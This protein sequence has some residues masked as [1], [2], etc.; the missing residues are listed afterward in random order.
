MSMNASNLN[1][2][3]KIDKHPSTGKK[4][5]AAM[6]LMV[7]CCTS[8]LSACSTT[9]SPAPVVD[10]STN[11]QPIEVNRTPAPEPAPI[12]S[13]APKA[14]ATDGPG[15]YTVKKGDTLIRIALDN[16][17]NF[18]D[19]V[20]WNNLSNPNDIKIDQV[21][22]V[23]P[24][25]TVAGGAQTERVV[26]APALD[27]SGNVGIQNK[28]G[29][30]GDKR[31]YSE[32]NLAELQKSDVGGQKATLATTPPVSP[33]APASNPATPA[34]SAVVNSGNDEQLTWVWPTEGKIL[35]GFEEGKNKGIDIGGKAGQQILSAGAGKVM[36]AGSVRGY[37]NLVI[38]RHSSNLLSA[39]AHNQSIL[40]KEGQ[41]VQKGQMIAEMGNS[42][43]DAVKLHFE[44]RQQGKPVDPTKFFPNRQ[45]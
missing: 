22:R 11:I 23:A 25:E 19:L 26:A 33:P 24:P 38:V 16:G 21:L 34:V 31:P 35:L 45:F 42:D 44:I 1:N 6:C 13:P 5:H 12:A 15:F 27:K 18:R 8:L 7:I 14:V 39:Y 10:R 9:K 3:G 36:Y 17:Q 4:M 43:S 29:P 28:S 41:S 32:A 40:V 2:V 30:R 20:L 37:G